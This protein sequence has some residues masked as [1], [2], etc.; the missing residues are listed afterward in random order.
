MKNLRI[1][2]IILLALVSAVWTT[3]GQRSTGTR[4]GNSQASKIVGTVL[5]K[6]DARIVGAVIKIKNARFSRT[7][8]S[9]T[10]G[11]FEV[12]LLAGAYQLTVE[13][14]GFKRFE[15]SPFQVKAGARE[16][17]NV[18]MEVKPP[19]STLKVE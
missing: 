9:D 10:E 12:E 2:F 3:A 13:M 11:V 5:D 17:V 7:V 16:Q 14:D 15:L 4:A 6:N 18:H 19:Q 1:T 8:I